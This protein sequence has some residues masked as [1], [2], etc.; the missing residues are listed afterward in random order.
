MSNATMHAPGTKIR[1]T[2]S[3]VPQAAGTRETIERMM[4]QDP[5]NAKALRN[6]QKARETKNNFYIRGNRIW[7]A[8]AKCA[9]I[10]HVKEGNSWEMTFTPQ[11]GNDM[12]AIS[13]YIAV[14]TI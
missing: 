5:A 11:V 9:K 10:V 2:I 4:R 7:G 8:R 3:K 14:E 13:D 1:C 6:S 12:A